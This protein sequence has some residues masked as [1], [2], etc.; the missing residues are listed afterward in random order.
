MVKKE[1]SASVVTRQALIDAFCLLHATQPVD[2]ITI[3]QLTKKAGVD[4]TTFYQYFLDRQDLYT[5]VQQDFV[6]YVLTYHAEVDVTDDQFVASLKQAYQDKRLFFNALLGPYGDLHFV[7]LLTDSF[8]R[9][10]P[11]ETGLA[12][13]QERPYLIE[14]QLM[15]SVSIF[16]LWLRRHDDLPFET[17]SKLARDLYLNGVTGTIAQ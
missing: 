15:T 6:D 10:L 8:Y 5:T 17:L 12:T 1:K 16:R 9:R 7:Q 14:F 4:R 13:A 11:E 2:K 3:S